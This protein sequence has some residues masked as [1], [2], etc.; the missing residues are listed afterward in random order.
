MSNITDL[1][2]MA[3][4]RD[5]GVLSEKEFQEEKNKLLKKEGVNENNSSTPPQNQTPT[6]TNV[7]LPNE[8]PRHTTVVMNTNK[9]SVGMA[10]LLW[11][12]LGWLGIHHLYM[13]RGVGVFLIALLTAQ[14]F[15]I[16]WILDIV[17]IPGS[18]AKDRGSPTIITH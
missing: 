15:G 10:Y 2:E 11:F 18:C 6:Q 12:F 7:I 4:L 9:P 5:E 3:K 8:Q 1:A 14:C 13:G 16:L 17:L